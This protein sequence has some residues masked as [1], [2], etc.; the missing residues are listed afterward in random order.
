VKHV[1]HKTPYAAHVLS[2]RSQAYGLS[3][4]IILI[5]RHTIHHNGDSQ[6]N[7][8]LLGLDIPE[9]GQMV[10]IFREYVDLNVATP[11]RIL[12]CLSRLLPLVKYNAGAY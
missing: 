10:S 2:R 7:A 9:V 8:I 5:M 1:I 3:Q 12:T 6:G 4:Q 11:L